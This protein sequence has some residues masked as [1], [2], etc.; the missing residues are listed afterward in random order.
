[1]GLQSNEHLTTAQ[2]SAYLDEEFTAQELALYATHVQTCLRCQA[3]LADLRVTSTLLRDLPRVDVPRSFVLPVAVGRPQVQR[4]QS[5]R[6]LYLR[7]TVRVLS[8]LAAVIGLLFL[9]VGGSALLPQGRYAASTASAPT[10]NGATGS[11][12]GTPPL[13]GSRSSPVPPE[14]ITT[15]AAPGATA[16]VPQRQTPTPTAVPSPSGVTPGRQVGILDLTQPPGRLGIGALL[17]VLGILGVV[18]TGRSRRELR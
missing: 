8:T 14:H 9:L 5:A 16:R 11:S 7:R 15:Q 2:L 6:P 18:L 17:L 12:A 13:A 1:M 10:L 3:V 4:P